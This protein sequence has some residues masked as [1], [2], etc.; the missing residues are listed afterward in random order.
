MS[1]INAYGL[2]AVAPYVFAVQLLVG[3]AVFWFGRWRWLLAYLC[4]V[5][6]IWFLSLTLYSAHCLA[7]GEGIWFIPILFLFIAAIATFAIRVRPVS[8]VR[9]RNDA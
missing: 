6:V 9:D 5:P 1:T 2:G 3:V 7:C 4:A 8:N